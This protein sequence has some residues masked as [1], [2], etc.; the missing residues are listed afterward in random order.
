MTP[1]QIAQAYAETIRRPANGW[2][3]HVHPTLG[4]SHAIMFKLHQMVGEQ[5]SDRLIDAAMKAA[6]QR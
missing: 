1:E 6:V 3:Q 2:G 5:E 4:V